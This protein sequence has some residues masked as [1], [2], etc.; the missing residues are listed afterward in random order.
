ML[1]SLLVWGTASLLLFPFP[2][3]Y[4]FRMITT[5]GGIVVWWLKVTCGVDYRVTGLENIP[6][7][8]LVIYAKH[9]STWETLFLL[10][11]FRPQTWVLKR[12]L[13]WLPV[14]GWAIALLRPIAIDRASGRAALRQVLRQGAE[15]LRDGIHIVVYPEGTR[16]PPGKRGRYGIGGALLAHH[17]RTPLLPVA[18]NAGSYWPR[19]GFLKRPGTI[20]VVIGPPILPDSGDA[21][22]LRAAGEAWIEDQMKRLERGRSPSL[23]KGTRLEKIY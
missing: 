7:G 5:W 15:R 23:G 13:L 3:R 10:R 16:V 21:E 17:T 18:H 1:C 2:Y 19:Q 4:R 20:D 9:Q 14:F 8:P 6:P 11:L 12:E 22:D